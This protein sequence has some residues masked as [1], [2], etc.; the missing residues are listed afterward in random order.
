[1]RFSKNDSR[2]RDCG[3][4]GNFIKLRQRPQCQKMTRFAHVNQ[5][6]TPYLI[7]HDGWNKE[8]L[9]IQNRL[10]ELSP[11]RITKQFDPP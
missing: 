4:E 8:S 2:I 6:I 3:I 1:M 9:T 11:T 5:S 10:K 7:S